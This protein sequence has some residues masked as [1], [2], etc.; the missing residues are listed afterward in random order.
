MPI[1][2]EC[3]QC[4]KRL[5]V[6]DASAG[7]RAK[8]P[9]CG[10][11]LVIPVRQ[12]AKPTATA[13]PTVAPLYSSPP[14]TNQLGNVLCRY[15]EADIYE[16]GIVSTARGQKKLLW[17]EVETIWF[18]SVLEHLTLATIGVA[19]IKEK[20]LT[21]EGPNEKIV[22]K[23]DSIDRIYPYVAAGTK[24]RLLGEAIERL[25][26][27]ETMKFG[28]WLSL[29]LEQ[30]S[31][32][33]PGIFWIRRCNVPWQEIAAINVSNGEMCVRERNPDVSMLMLF[34]NPSDA[35]TKI[36]AIPNAEVLLELCNGLCFL[37][38]EPVVRTCGGC[39]KPVALTTS[40][41]RHCWAMF[42]PE[43]QSKPTPRVRQK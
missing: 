20:K 12:T 15:A 13:P 24:M 17:E 19:S 37:N 9:G 34:F 31:F 6:K 42:A 39:S 23:G 35:S 5:T 21:L 8:C 36:F 33:R 28:R 16:G 41:C 10:G 40:F 38:P 43:P 25:R 18:H 1:S 14:A 29:N 27:K 4:E 30:F 22:I 26:A 3:P 11:T 7:K 32:P 2:V